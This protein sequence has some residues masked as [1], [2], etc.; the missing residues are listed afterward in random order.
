MQYYRS[1]LLS[2]LLVGY[3]FHGQPIVAIDIDSETIKV[4]IYQHEP[5]VFLDKLGEPS[6]FWPELLDAIAEDE[7]WT[8][9]YVPCEWRRSK[10]VT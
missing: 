10:R 5:K 8:V 6:R 4:G 1:V 3:S 2:S 9:E 7:N